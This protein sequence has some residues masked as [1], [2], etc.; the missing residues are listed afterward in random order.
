MTAEPG[1]IVD[2]STLDVAAAA[3]AEAVEPGRPQW[4]VGQRGS[5]RSELLERLALHR[6][7]ICVRTVAPEHADAAMHAVVQAAAGITDAEQRRRAAESSEPRAAARAVAECLADDDVTLAVRLHASW[8]HTERPFDAANSDGAG[9]DDRARSLR[10][11]RDVLQAWTS[12]PRLRLVLI[13]DRNADPAAL[14]VDHGSDHRLQPLAVV[15]GVLTEPA[16]WGTLADAAALVSTIPITAPLDAQTLRASVAASALGIGKARLTQILAC[17]SSSQRWWQL[18]TA[19]R[20]RIAHHSRLGSVLRSLLSLRVPLPIER[21]DEF[22][23]DDADLEHLLVHGLGYGVTELRIAAPIRRE[24]SATLGAPSAD[25]HARLTDFC[26]QL[27]GAPQHWKTSAAAWW[28]EKHHHALLAGELRVDVWE[29]AAD[30]FPGPAWHWL[31]GR[32]LSRTGHHERAASVYARAVERFPNDSY[33]WHYLGF[34]LAHAGLRRAEAQSAYQ[35]AIELEPDNPWWN[36]RLVTFLV[37]QGRF[38]EA[39]RAWSEALERLDPDGDRCCQ[40]PWLADHVHRW[41]A[42]AWHD[43]GESERASAVLAQLPADIIAASS[44]LRRLQHDIAD[45]LEAEQL[46]ESVYPWDVPMDQR[47]KAPRTITEDDASHVVQWAP[48]RVVDVDEAVRVV[49]ALASEPAEPKRIALRELSQQEWRELSG[50][51]PPKANTYFE[52]LRFSDG[53]VRIA[54]VPSTPHDLD[55]R[56]S[57][58]ARAYLQRWHSP[59]PSH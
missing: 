8:S 12:H 9:D 13:T 31:R 48:G 29:R 58:I 34:N 49:Y 26:Q 30:D 39:Q 11:V 35:R 17:N 50:G 40:D 45:A 44:R 47:W 36:S 53:S 6:R 21:L 46:G 25:E 37:A 42:Q 14:G 54:I 19:L 55:P 33:S 4:V 28:L 27:D 23:S 22:V 1:A 52:L 3:I 20:E 59:Q 51:Q 18:A 43:A 41:V 38:A 32:Q 16:H 10:H 5:G 24:L 56:A 15:D 7:T 2:L 57:A